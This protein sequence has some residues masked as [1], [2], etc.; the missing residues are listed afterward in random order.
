MDVSRIQGAALS[1]VGD[2]KFPNIA[3]FGS[4][5]LE[6]AAAILFAAGTSPS[7][8][9]HINETNFAARTDPVVTSL[10]LVRE[11]DGAGFA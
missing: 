2:G 11:E 3:K 8:K 4:I 6:A 1:P 7:P 9:G 5:L 10:C